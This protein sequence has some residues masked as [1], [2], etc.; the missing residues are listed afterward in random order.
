MKLHLHKNE[1]RDE[2]KIAINHF[3]EENKP[4]NTTRFPHNCTLSITLN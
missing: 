3:F 2:I 1:L 4:T